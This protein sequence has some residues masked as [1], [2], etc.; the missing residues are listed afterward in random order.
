MALGAVGATRLA[1]FVVGRNELSRRALALVRFTVEN[2]AVETLV[3]RV[4]FRAFDA[5]PGA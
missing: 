3:T 2:A 5:V 1:F 4:L